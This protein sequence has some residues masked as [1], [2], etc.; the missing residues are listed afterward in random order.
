MTSEGNI[1]SG[2]QIKQTKLY[3]TFFFTKLSSKLDCFLH[4]CNLNYV[5][6]FYIKLSAK[7]LKVSHSMKEDRYLSYSSYE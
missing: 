4:V 1:M 5:I 2:K 3:K 6:H 7:Q